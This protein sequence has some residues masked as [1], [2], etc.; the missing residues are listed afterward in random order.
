MGSKF[1]Y[2]GDG[3]VKNRWYTDQDGVN[4]LDRLLEKGDNRGF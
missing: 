4:L 2:V 3:S 1:I